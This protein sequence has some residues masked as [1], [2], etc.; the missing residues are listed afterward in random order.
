MKSA[1]KI[2]L[3]QLLP[4]APVSLQG[5]EVRWH[6]FNPIVRVASLQLGDS[7][8]EGLI[9]KPDWMESLWRRG[10]VLRHLSNSRAQLR[11]EQTTAGTWALAGMPSGTGSVNWRTLLEHSDQLLVHAEVAFATD[12]QLN[13]HLAVEV[14]ARNQ[15]GRRRWELQLFEPDCAASCRLAV[16][17]EE[18]LRVPGLQ[19]ASLAILASTVGDGV[20]LPAALLGGTA[21]RVARADVRWDASARDWR[22]YAQKVRGWR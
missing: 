2:L 18:R 14:N 10:P 15:R 6:R 9:V 21:L 20:R 8:I 1:R 16:E 4:G 17:L 5:F 12:A 11:F 22:S 13:P 7:R 19:A 3:A